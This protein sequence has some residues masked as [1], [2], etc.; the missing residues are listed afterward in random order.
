[1]LRLE[2]SF[3]KYSRYR[4]NRQKDTKGTPKEE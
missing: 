2:K 1:M 3:F 4:E